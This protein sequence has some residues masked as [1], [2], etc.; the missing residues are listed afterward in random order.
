MNINKVISKKITK[1]YDLNFLNNI[2]KEN[3]CITP[4]VPI[5]MSYFPFLDIS[6]IM[7]LPFIALEHLQWY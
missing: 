2:L 5:Y 3:L 7:N 6:K 4:S 1:N